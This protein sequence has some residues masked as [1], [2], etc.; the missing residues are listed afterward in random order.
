MIGGQQG[1]C[2]IYLHATY[3]ILYRRAG[4]SAGIADAVVNGIGC[5]IAVMVMVFM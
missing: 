1:L 4:V 3:G 2:R 5:R